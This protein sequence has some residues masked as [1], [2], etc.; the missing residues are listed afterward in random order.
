MKNILSGK[1]VHGAATAVLLGLAAAGWQR[2]WQR[3]DIIAGQNKEIT[4]QDNVLLATDSLLQIQRKQLDAKSVQLDDTCW[5]LATTRAQLS[6]AQ[7]EL[8]AN[9]SA[10][11]AQVAGMLGRMKDYKDLAEKAN[12]DGVEA[13]T[14]M[15]QAFDISWKAY[16]AERRLTTTLLS[17]ISL[18]SDEKLSLA[19]L[20][21][22]A[23]NAKTATGKQYQDVRAYLDE[24]LPR[25]PGRFTLVR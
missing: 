4:R 25:A 18:F 1:S 6:A 7:E 21:V 9:T 20:T 24:K 10:H 2:A 11:E 13:T 16:V 15:G 14:K 19:E 8:A 17:Q 3:A 22:F 5:E 12:K 23:E